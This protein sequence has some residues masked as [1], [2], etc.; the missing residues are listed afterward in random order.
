MSNTFENSVNEYLLELKNQGVILEGSPVGISEHLGTS[1]VKVSMIIGD[2]VEEKYIIVYRVND[3]FTWKFFKQA[4]NVVL[5]DFSPTGWHYP[6]F[7]KRIVAP[8]NLALQ[9]PQFEVW[10]RLNN[11]PIIKENEALYCYCNEILPEHQSL[12]DSLSGVITVENR[13]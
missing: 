10:F 7:N 11:L 12:I 5:Y 9:Y 13:V 2:N 1:H 4:D 8:L 6:Y 3:S